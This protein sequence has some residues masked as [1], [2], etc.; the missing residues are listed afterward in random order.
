[1]RMKAAHSYISHCVKKKVHFYL[2]KSLFF[3]FSVTC[4]QIFLRE[5]PKTWLCMKGWTLSNFGHED[6]EFSVISI[7][8]WIVGNK[9]SGVEQHKI[10]IFLR[11]QMRSVAEP[12]GCLFNI[13]SPSSCSPTCPFPAPVQVPLQ[14]PTQSLQDIGKLVIQGWCSANCQKDK[15]LPASIFRCK[16]LR[17]GV[18]IYH[19]LP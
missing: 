8:G 2:L 10:L 7:S 13:C 17:Y 5:K 1:M 9:Q 15:R 11:Y 18:Q 14:P 16:K 6:G 19:G 4:N 3:N 12:A